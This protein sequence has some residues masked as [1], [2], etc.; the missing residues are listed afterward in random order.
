MN[1]H[2]KRTGVIFA[3]VAL[4]VL[5]STGCY[6]GKFLSNDGG[7]GD[8]GDGGG[9]TTSTSS[10][11]AGGTGSGGTGGGEVCNPACDDSNPCTDDV[12]SAGTCS[13]PAAL[14][15]TLSDDPNDCKNPVCNSK[16]LE[17]V[18]DDT[19]TPTDD[20]NDCTLETCVGGM[21][22]PFAGTGATCNGTGVCNS[23]GICSSCTVPADC[24]ADN[25]C[26]T[27]A[28]TS[29]VC[30]PSYVAV[31]IEVANP[32]P[33]DCKATFCNGTGTEIVGNKNSDFAV[34]A[35]ECLVNS[36]TSGTPQTNNAP[37]MTTCGNGPSCAGSYAVNPQDTCVSGTCNSPGAT[38]C[39]LYA[40]NPAT[41]ACRTI[42][43][44]HTECESTSYCG[45]AGTPEADNLCHGKKPAAVACAI[46]Q[47][48]QSGTCVAATCT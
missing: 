48:C 20:G 24:G 25:L 9:A 36:C 17:Q 44:A 32:T 43:V 5:G 8:G 35:N 30:E 26:V 27:W 47:E 28:C 18:N 46:D 40:C 2:A 23:M 1:T 29:N 22:H 6:G 41:N 34:N 11:G 7:G 38:D 10:V 33:N 16:I 14:A 13:Y 3:S 12:C 4:V 37:P 19:E 39:G 15:P 45:T 21:P 42:C 31:N